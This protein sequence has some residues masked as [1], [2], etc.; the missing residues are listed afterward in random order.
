MKWILHY[1][2]GATFSDQDG[3]VY[4]APGLDVQLI[5]ME[6]PEHGRYH[7][8]GSDCYV[9]DDRG[10]GERWWGVDKFGLWEYLKDPGPKKVVFGRTITNAA[11]QKIFHDAEKHGYIPAHTAFRSDERRP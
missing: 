1:S 4:D 5:A 6:D 2:S 10:D 3:S 11:F 8:A 7:Q 9:W